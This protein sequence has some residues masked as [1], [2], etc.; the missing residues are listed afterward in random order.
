M[1]VEMREAQVEKDRA[2]KELDITTKHNENAVNLLHTL[3]SNGMELPTTMK[4]FET[5]L[6][7]GD[8]TTGPLSA[9]ANP[10]DAPPPPLMALLPRYCI[11]LFYSIQS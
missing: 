7:R 5:F 10:S 11:S 3:L 1:K 2:P 9:A 4:L 8:T 6:N